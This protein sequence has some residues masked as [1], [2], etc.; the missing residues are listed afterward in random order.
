M[1]RIPL[2]AK[3]KKYFYCGDNLKIKGFHSPDR[4]DDARIKGMIV[5]KRNLNKVG[6]GVY[7]WIDNKIH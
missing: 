1:L 7:C 6:K 2:F 4:F 3:P 5:K